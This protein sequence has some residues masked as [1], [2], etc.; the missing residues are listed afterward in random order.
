MNEVSWGWHCCNLVGSKIFHICWERY[1]S[2]WLGNNQEKWNFLS[3]IWY[4]N[5]FPLLVGTYYLLALCLLKTHDNIKMHCIT[6]VTYASSTIPLP[7]L[8][9]KWTIF[10]QLLPSFAWNYFCSTEDRAIIFYQ[11]RTVGH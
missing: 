2:F 1:F 11:I 9:E 4:Y 10:L 5:I 6:C 7:S 8:H 3:K